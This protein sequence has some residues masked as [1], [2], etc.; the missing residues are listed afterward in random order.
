MGASMNQARSIYRDRLNSVVSN[1]E[2]K[3]ASSCVFFDRYARCYACGYRAQSEVEESILNCVVINRA[4]IS[5]ALQTARINTAKVFYTR[6]CTLMG[7]FPPTLV[8]EKL[9][10]C[11][12]TAEGHAL[13]DGLVF[14]DSL[15]WRRA[16]HYF[17][18]RFKDD[19]SLTFAGW[20]LAQRGCPVIRDG[21][22]IELLDSARVPRTKV[23]QIA[24]GLATRGLPFA[25]DF[26]GLK[27]HELFDHFRFETICWYGCKG[28]EWEDVFSSHI[29]KH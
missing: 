2:I 7:L 27:R 5:D 1:D 20:A 16:L 26:C 28:D 29:S 12:V 8:T 21:K 9:N 10:E 19:T 4:E 25:K 13:I 24:F 6:F 14:F 17:I 18:D 3:S 11:E 22:F 23:A 15:A